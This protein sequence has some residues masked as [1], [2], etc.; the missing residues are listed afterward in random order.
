LGVVFGVGVYYRLMDGQVIFKVFLLLA[1]ILFTTLLVAKTVGRHRFFAQVWKYKNAL[2]VLIV[3]III[4][5]FSRAF[6]IRAV[7]NAAAILAYALGLFHIV[8]FAQDKLKVKIRNFN[9]QDQKIYLIYAAGLVGVFVA[10]TTMDPS[11]PYGPRFQLRIVFWLLLAHLLGSW[12]LGQWKLVK[13]LQN[14]RTKA[15]LMHLK[16]QVNPH[17]FFNTL[18]NLYGL[19]REKSDDTPALILKLSDMMRYTIYQGK[20]ERVKVSDE[21]AYLNNFIELQQIRFHQPVDVEFVCSIDK[22]D[23]RITPLL[24]IILLENAY[25]HGVEKMVEGAY[26]RLNLT[27]NEQQL[28]FTIENN[29]DP[30]EMSVEPGIGLENLKRR[31][32][33]IYPEHHQLNVKNQDNCYAVTLTIKLAKIKQDSL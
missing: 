14:E 23:Y 32:S 3:V 12:L 31:L 25:K 13:Q 19:A 24:L 1:Y 21:V 9:L 30:E 8:T 29:Y 27:I 18:N 10:T 28:V 5:V 7:Y 17:F 2:S 22:N 26:V 6:H 20:K 15:E 16:S 4:V 11:D 33:L